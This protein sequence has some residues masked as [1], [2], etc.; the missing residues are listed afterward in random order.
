MRDIRNLSLVN[1]GPFNVR[2]VEKPPSI[3][4]L[5]P[6]QG[7]MVLQ[8]YFL[9][10]SILHSHLTPSLGVNPIEFLDELFIP[11]TTVRR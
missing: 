7:A 5:H 2:S 10:W 6:S 3:I 4:S 11:K 1:Y 9:T 8:L